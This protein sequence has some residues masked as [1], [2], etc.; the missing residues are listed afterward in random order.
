MREKTTLFVKF[1]SIILMLFLLG[2]PTLAQDETNLTEREDEHGNLRLENEYIAIVVNQSD[3]AMGR[4]AVETTGGDPARDDDEN[5]PMIY[6]RPQPWPSYTTVKID[7]DNYVFGGET[8]RRAGE[9]EKYGELIE[10]PQVVGDS[11]VTIF[12]LGGLEVEQSLMFERSSTTGLYDTARVEYNMTNT[13]D[14]KK[15]VGLRI[16]L[17]TMLGEND[18]APFRIQDQAITTD[19]MFEGEELPNF[20]QSF[21]SLTDP[22]VTSQGTFI[23]ESVDTP[24][25][26]YMSDWGSLA[27]EAW[28]FNF[29]PG[30]E[31]V[32]EGEFEIDSAIAMYWD[33]VEIESEETLTYSTNYG[34]A[35]ISMV[36]GLLSLGVTSPSE[37]AFSES[38]P[39]FPVVAYIEN[40]AEI[41]AENAVA[42]L[43][44]PDELA[45]DDLERNIGD[46]EEGEVTQVNWNVRADT[47]DLPD[48]LNFE[49]EVD[50][51]NTDSNLA[52]RELNV[53]APA[54]LE[55]SLS[56]VEEMV[57]KEGDLYPVPYTIR[58]EIENIGGSTFYGFESEMILPPGLDFASY[59][60]PNKNAGRIKPGE[61][62]TIDWKVIPLDVEGTFPFAVQIRG[63]DGYSRTLRERVNIPATSPTV[64]MLADRSSD[65]VD[66]LTLKINGSYLDNIEDISFNL[67][68]DENKVSPVYFTRGT[69]FVR[70]G[71]LMAWAGPENNTSDEILAFDEELPADID[72]GGLAKVILR[73]KEKDLSYD[74]LGL[75]ISD[76][77]ATNG[78]GEEIDIR[79]EQIQLEEEK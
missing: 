58:A 75:E 73:L 78:D 10:E 53:I 49:V 47:D 68:Y 45:S 2:N 37:F 35:G 54:E 62:L 29:N 76:L 64:Y 61:K 30:E 23:G 28:D 17:D 43:S 33:P 41:T 67:N 55:A 9:G 34:L 38:N 70:D 1:I 24:D 79:I 20:Y 25:K 4:F 40:T 52:E 6:G 51:D 16:M 57:L 12:E 77:V 11:I 66:Y 59:E 71:R 69:A 21:D 72:S 48:V 46:L 32:R 39:E 74:E 7:D 8:E 15:S 5:K 36:P 44:L 27:D 3:N 13:T 18:G 50:A 14:E 26:V 19:T 56:A 42:R 63:Q 22:Q 60:K 31:F 65:E